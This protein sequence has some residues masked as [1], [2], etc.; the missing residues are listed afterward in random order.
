MVF[1]A[2]AMGDSAAPVLIVDEVDKLAP[3][4]GANR[5]TPINT[6]LDLL[7]EESA[8]RYRDMSLQLQMDASR[9]I[10]ICT[11]NDRERIAPPLLSRLTEFHI[12]PPTADQRRLILEQYLERLIETHECPASMALDAASGEAA[13]AMQDLDVRALLRMVRAGFA[14]A[15]AAGSDRVIL[16]PAHRRAGRQRIGF[17]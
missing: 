7:E 5:D 10:V 11:A 3:E 6:L 2:L 16:T 9:L 1:D 17:I 14:A 8:R 13:V 15:L 12:A 4:S